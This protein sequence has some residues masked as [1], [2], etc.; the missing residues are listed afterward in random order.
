MIYITTYQATLVV[1]HYVL[2]LALL[3]SCL[4]R[5]THTTKHRTRAS[6]RWAFNLLSLAAVAGV[7]A[8]LVPDHTHG[9]W[10]PD[11]M[12]VLLLFAITLVQIATATH[13]KH[14]VPPQFRTDSE[15]AELQ[16]HQL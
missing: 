10:L 9:R 5:F 15:R 3:W 2:C 1:L 7:V 14:G 11:A 6:I 12:H 16:E 4:C 8:P 13:W